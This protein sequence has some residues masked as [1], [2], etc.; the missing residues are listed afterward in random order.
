MAE[1]D[2][3]LAR[4]AQVAAKLTADVGAEHVADVYAKAFLGVTEKAGQTEALIEQLNQLFSKAIDPYPRLETILGSVLISPEE[5]EG[6]IDRVFAP[7][8]SP[9]LTNFL[10]VVARH[11]RLDCLRAIRYRIAAQYDALRKRL[12]VELTTATA[13]SPAVGS[14]IADQLRQRL[15]ADPVVRQV[16]DPALIGGAVIRVGDTVFDGSVANQLKLIC[17]Q[18]I[19]RSAHEIQ[20]RRNRFRDSAGN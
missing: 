14:R 6:I 5:K 18:M 1:S 17:E 12:P 7:G 19:D 8:I 4:D 10:K 15:G 11:G 3:Y 9:L 16:V 13:I 20:S 2:D